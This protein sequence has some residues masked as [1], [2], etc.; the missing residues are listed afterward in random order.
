L[1]KRVIMAKELIKAVAYLRTSSRTNTGPD[2]DTDKRQRKAIAEYA[3]AAGYEIV[4]EFYDIAVSGADPVG[5][6]PGFAAMLEALLANGARTI[7]V[8]SPDRFA[9]DLMVQLAGH[10]MLK[11]RGIVLIAAS[12]PA[13]FTEDTPTAILVRQ[14]LGAIAEFD[15]TTL[16]AKLAA[17]R[18]RKREA[19][20]RKVGGRKSHA[21][22]RPD[23]VAIVRSLARKRPKGGRMSLRAISAELAARGFV[24]ERGAPFNPKSIGAMLA[25][26]GSW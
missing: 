22:E 9:R 5:G 3:R 12:A 19:T 4:A 23:L 25:R 24:N 20:G 17:A 13:H 26:S 10:D 21:E 11:Q 15:K 2:K 6:R 14:V 16:V 18:R 8:E 1:K 7:V